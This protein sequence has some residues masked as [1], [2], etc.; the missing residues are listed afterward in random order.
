MTKFNQISQAISKTLNSSPQ[1]Y[2]VERATWLPE[3]LESYILSEDSDALL[4]RRP[5]E[6]VSPQILDS[7]AED[8]IKRHKW[9]S[10]FLSGGSSLLG[11]A[12]L[13]LS[14]AGDL[15]LFV[16]ELSL[17]TQ[18]LAYLYGWNDFFPH[19]HPTRE[20]VARLSVI[21]AYGLGVYD[22]KDVLLSVAHESNPLIS[23]K[24]DSLGFSLSTPGKNTLVARGT[25]YVAKSLLAGAVASRSVFWGMIINGGYN[26]FAFERIARRMQQILLEMMSR[27]L[28]N[29]QVLAP[30]E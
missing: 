9:S 1:L 24:L 6:F 18:K 16:R 26:C 13:L 19:G 20:T 23:K 4:H 12:S 14:A 25:V 5:E 2:R 17:L 15:T 8:L 28:E 7:I 30:E 10:V 21:I 29:E 22:C 27:R 11:K 3:V